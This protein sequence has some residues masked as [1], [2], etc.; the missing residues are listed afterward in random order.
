MK[1]LGES[2]GDAGGHQPPEVHGGIY[3]CRIICNNQRSTDD[4]RGGDKFGV[5]HV[6]FAQKINNILFLR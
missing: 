3:R 1:Y 6:M 4:K 5:E 2:F